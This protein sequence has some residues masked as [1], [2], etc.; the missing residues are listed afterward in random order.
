MEQDYMQFSPFIW[1]KLAFFLFMTVRNRSR[2]LFMRELTSLEKE[3]GRE[4]EMMVGNDSINKN[5]KSALQL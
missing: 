2:H 1:A 4:R 5:V 3:R